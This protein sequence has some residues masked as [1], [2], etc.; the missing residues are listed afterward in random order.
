[1]T[2]ED[3][4]DDRFFST[5]VPETD[6]NRAQLRSKDFLDRISAA[7]DIR[8]RYVHTGVSFGAWIAPGGLGEIQLGRPVMEDEELSKLLAIAP[9]YSGW[10]V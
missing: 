8:S 10:S 2:V 4:I 7:Y 5:T 6:T 3:L 9:T 1:L